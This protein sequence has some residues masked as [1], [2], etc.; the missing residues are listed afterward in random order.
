MT[1][2]P[3]DSTGFVGAWTSTGNEVIAMRRLPAPA[4]LDQLRGLCSGAMHMALIEGVEKTPQNFVA[5]GTFNTATK[6]PQG[7][8][9]TMPAY[10]R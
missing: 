2:L 7:N 1:P 9:V 3:C 10:I 8:F 5:A 4:D 6:D